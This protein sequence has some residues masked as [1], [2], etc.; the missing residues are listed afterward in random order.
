MVCV[1]VTNHSNID[2]LDRAG[3]EA[4]GIVTDA[5]RLFEN[6][7]LKGEAAFE[8]THKSISKFWRI[9]MPEFATHLD[10]IDAIVGDASAI[11]GPAWAFNGQS[12][13]EKKGIPFVGAHLWPLG[14]L[15]AYDPPVLRDIPALVCNPRSKLAIAWNQCIIQIA[16]QVMKPM[17]AGYLNPPRAA[18]GLG[19]IKR[20]PVLDFQ[21]EPARVLGL[22]S[23]HFAPRPLDM[24]QSVELTGFPLIEDS[25]DAPDPQLDEFMED[26]PM[27]FN[28]GS[29]LSENPGSFYEA[30]IAA[31]ERL[32]Q[33]ALIL[34]GFVAQIGV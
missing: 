17:F 23:S 11:V 15:S 5:I 6:A 31:A 3:F 12:V 13:A 10:E 24:P 22:Y 8:A 2:A 27:V 25:A 21:L 34:S 7:G 16:K 29:I 1:F 18:Y 14:V 33:K 26:A 19:K 9:V 20:T 4:Y 28:L 32:G 30:S